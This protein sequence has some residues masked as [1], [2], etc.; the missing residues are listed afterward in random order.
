MIPKVELMLLH[1]KDIAEEAQLLSL[2]PL[3]HFWQ[4]LALKHG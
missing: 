2:M 1:Q 3:C 4:G